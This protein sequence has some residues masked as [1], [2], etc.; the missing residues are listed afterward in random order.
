MIYNLS[1]LKF[2]KQV[3]I[4]DELTTLDRMKSFVIESLR[5]P[6]VEFNAIN[7]IIIR[8]IYDKFYLIISPQGQK[9]ALFS[10]LRSSIISEALS[11]YKFS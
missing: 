11:G 7:Y 2:E 1:I 3:L 10:K 6:Q 5:P 4:V 9:S 8:K